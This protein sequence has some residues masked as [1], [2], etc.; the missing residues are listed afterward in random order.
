MNEYIVYFELYGKK[1]KA[2]VTA[3]SKQEAEQAIKNKII[4]HKTTL[5]D[6]DHQIPKD[7]KDF[8]GGIFN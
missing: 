1:M 3:Y 8:F 4:F 6:L 2:T 5:K 7:L